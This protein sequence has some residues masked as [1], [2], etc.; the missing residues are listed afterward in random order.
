MA[1][2]TGQEAPDFELADSE[3]GKTKLSDFRGKKNVLLVFYPLAFS[4]ICSQEF[5]TLRDH[6]ADLASTE[7]LEVIG[8]SVDSRWA[9]QRWKQEEGFPVRFVS[10]FWPHGAVAQAYGVFI[11][12]RGIAGRGTFLVDK[13]GVVRW[14]EVNP[15]AEARDQQGWRKA[16][17]EMGPLERDRRE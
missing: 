1:V 14:K 5:C 10:D 11:P 15:P 6:N 4:T 7:D 17:A 2:D 12:E 13:A 8:I 3:G 16:L 9:L